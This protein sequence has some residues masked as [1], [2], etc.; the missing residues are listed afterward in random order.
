M[1][2]NSILDAKFE[3]RGDAKF[4]AIEVGLDNGI[5]WVCTKK[6]IKNMPDKKSE[7]VFSQA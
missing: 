3:M 1:Y 6:D 7:D 4:V 5:Y 2:W